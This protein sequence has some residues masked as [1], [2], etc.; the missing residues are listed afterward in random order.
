MVLIRD[1]AAAERQGRIDADYIDSA[2]ELLEACL[3]TVYPARPSVPSGD[4]ETEEL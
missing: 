1:I 2:A 4:S 3:V